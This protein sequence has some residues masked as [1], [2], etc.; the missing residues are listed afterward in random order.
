MSDSSAPGGATRGGGGV[1]LRKNRQRCDGLYVTRG[2][3][4]YHC[5]G[6][7]YVKRVDFGGRARLLIKTS[8]KKL[9][10]AKSSSSDVKATVRGSYGLFSAAVDASR[11]TEE[12]KNVYEALKGS[13][14][15]Q[16]SSPVYRTC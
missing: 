15:L 3:L 6:S 10:E 14:I 4:F 5:S 13:Q 2:I 16:S 8:A 1:P 11:A 7:H 9:A 12:Q